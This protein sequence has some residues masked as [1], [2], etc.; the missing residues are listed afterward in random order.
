M[1]LEKWAYIFFVFDFVARFNV[2]DIFT[3][4]YFDTPTLNFTRTGRLV[5]VQIVLTDKYFESI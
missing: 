2:C 5:Y 4:E 3:F 1:Y